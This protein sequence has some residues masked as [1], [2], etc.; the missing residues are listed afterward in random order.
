MRFRKKPELVDA[1]QWTG[2]NMADITDLDNLG[3]SSSGYAWEHE[4]G[5][6]IVANGETEIVADS[7]DWIIRYPDGTLEV[8]KAFEFAG[9][10]ERI[11]PS[12]MPWIDTHRKEDT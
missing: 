10:Y 4:T 8:C 5:Q 7:G 12:A 3:P 2:Q 6:L 11:P 9:R 1:V